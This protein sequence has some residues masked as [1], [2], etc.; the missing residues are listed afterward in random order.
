MNRRYAAKD[1]QPKKSLFYLD[2]ALFVV[3]GEDV[4]GKVF[5]KVYDAA[6]RGKTFRDSKTIVE[7]H[8]LAWLVHNE[9]LREIAPGVY[10][11]TRKKE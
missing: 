9:H 6:V 1:M 5:V 10:V 4:P 7:H 8:A 3:N 2:E 11:P